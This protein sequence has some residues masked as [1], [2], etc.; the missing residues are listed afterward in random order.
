MIQETNLKVAGPGCQWTW[1]VVLAGSQ[2]TKLKAL[3]Q[4]GW[5]QPEFEPTWL[6]GHSELSLAGTGH[7]V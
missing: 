4:H 2:T 5:T 1:P 3:D 6:D 7:S